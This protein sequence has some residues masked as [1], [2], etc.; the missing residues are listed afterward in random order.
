MYVEVSAPA[1][2]ANLGAGFDILGMACAEPLDVIRAERTETPG[3]V[4]DSITG[5]GGRLTRDPLKNT[6]GIAATFVLNQLG[7]KEGLKLSI[8]KGLPLESGLGSSAASAVAGAVAANAVFGEPLKRIDLLPACLEGEAAV[9]GRHAD[10]VAPA[11]LGGIT[12]ITSAE[13]VYA[14]PIPPDLYIALVTPAVAVPTAQ[15]RA[16]LPKMIPLGQM[17]S[18]T[19][20]VGLLITAIHQ[21]D[22]ALMA[23]AMERDCVIEPAREHLMPGLREV[24]TAARAAG[25]LTTVISGA[26]PTL[27]SICNSR[28]IAE[29]V[30]GA[31]AQVYQTLKIEAVTRVTTPLAGG[32][33][34]KLLW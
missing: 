10:N 27:C 5:D 1:T 12:L 16:V 19:A 25:A 11:L 9:S 14:L 2:I 20:A 31:M 30:T 32:A 17:V 15:A 22:V 8:V 3:V 6:A 28:E 7:V 34:V 24:R 29:A 13:S 18:Q 21:G 26:G 33:S 23:A 4:I